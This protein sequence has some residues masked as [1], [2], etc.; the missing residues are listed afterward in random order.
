MELLEKPGCVARNK[1]FDDSDLMNVFTISVY[2][3]GTSRM[4][5]TEYAVR[6]F[7]G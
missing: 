7:T 5:E 4:P 1:S 3:S 6:Q 2:A